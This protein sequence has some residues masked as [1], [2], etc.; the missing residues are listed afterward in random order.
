MELVLGIAPQD[1]YDL[2]DHPRVKVER[3]K[4]IRAAQLH[5]LLELRRS[6]NTCGCGRCADVR[7]AT[8]ETEP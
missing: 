8:L 1:T 6:R 7:A 5:Y 4:A 3:V 2:D